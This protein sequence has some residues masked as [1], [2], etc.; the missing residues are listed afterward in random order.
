MKK[1]GTKKG[2]KGDNDLTINPAPDSVIKNND[3]S[4]LLTSTCETPKTSDTAKK[5]LFL[6]ST[7]VSIIKKSLSYITIYIFIVDIIIL[8]KHLNKNV[9]NL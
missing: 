3:K 1:C 9:S 8:I 2:R 6:S 5:N 7:P 4:I